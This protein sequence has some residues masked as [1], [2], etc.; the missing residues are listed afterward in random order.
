MGDDARAERSVQFGEELL[1]LCE[2]SEAQLKALTALGQ[3]AKEHLPQ[4]RLHPGTRGSV[5]GWSAT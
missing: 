3:M 5:H 4:G 2:V 1:P